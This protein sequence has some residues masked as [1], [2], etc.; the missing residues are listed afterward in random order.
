MS[1]I[2][3][4]TYDI[5]GK[6][7]SGGG[8]IVYLATHK[9]L[10]K[11]VVLKA[12]KRSTKTRTELLRRE[13]DILKELTNTYIPQV[14]DYF[15]EGDTSYTVMDYVEG[16]SLNK[17]LEREKRF[18]QPVVIKWARQLLEALVYLHSPTH[19]DPPRGYIHSDIKPG[20]IMLRPSGDI[21]LIDFNISLAIGIESIVGRSP[22]YSSPEH[23]GLDY[24]A[25]LMGKAD[26]AET[27][28]ETSTDDGRDV[29]TV[30]ES[31]ET[32]TEAAVGKSLQST[33]GS[34]LSSSLKR[35]TVLDARSDIYSVGATLYHLLSGKRPKNDAR[36][37][38]PLS[39]KEF[40]PQLV[41]IITK[42]M[43]PNPDMRYATAAEMLEAING[44]WKNDPRVKRRKKQTI[45]VAAVL[46]LIYATG[47]AAIYAGM[48]QMER[49]QA[50]QV[51]AADSS[52]AFS[53]GDVK[54]ALD[55]ALEAL[56][57][58]PGMFDLP[59]TPQAQ[60]ALTD[61]LGIYDLSDSFKPY[62]K[63]NLPSAPFRTVKSPDGT[64]FIVTYAYELAIYDFDTGQP[65][66]TMPTLESAL[67][68]VEFLND[69]KIV[70]GGKEGL[71]AYD[72]SS[73]TV[74]WEVSPATAIAVSGDSQTV[75]AI[76]GREDK[77]SF[78]NAVTGE[79]ITE[80]SLEGRHLNIP[81][82]DMYA[83]AMRDVFELDEKGEFCA[84]SLS[85][86]YLG[87]L[88]IKDP[89]RD[90]IIFD[91]T[92]DHGYTHFEGA[93][94]KNDFAFS[95][96][97]NKGALFGIIDCKDVAY[98]GD[99]TSDSLYRLKA[100]KDKLYV[101]QNATAVEFNT[102]TFEQTE[103]AFTDTNNINAFDI[104]DNYVLAATPEG[105]S[106][107]YG[108]AG[109]LQSNTSEIPQDFVLV[110][111]RFIAL[112]DRNSPAIEVL[113]LQSHDDM[114][115]ISYD[116]QIKHYEARL[117]SDRSSVMLFGID[118]FTI[119]NADGGV[120]LSAA[121]PEPDKIYDQQ[122]RRDGGDCLEVTYYSGKIVSYS[123]DN[124][125]II[126][127]TEGSPPDKG[128]GEEF[129]TEQFIIKA[130]LQGTPTVYSKESGEKLTDLSSEDDLTYITEVDGYIIA[131]YRGTD[132]RY[133]G[134]LMNNDCEPIAR[135]PNLCDISGNSLVF[136]FPSGNI[137][138]SPIYELDELK[139]RA[140][141][142]WN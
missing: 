113:R 118:G 56:P 52:K 22:G 127:E 3:D 39:A 101:I 71:T 9:R 49:L 2:I 133:Y 64:K 10:G 23:Y 24:S 48:H 11:K 43:N 42:A 79:L 96:Y 75:A 77:I 125:E 81:E 38:E 63:I 93:F 132:G 37:V 70:F 4:S 36:E 136:D 29:T 65:I 95:A 34:S 66:K 109:L 128:A 124:G 142:Y 83:D 138:I 85:G 32:V 14:Y 115:L 46:A 135:L 1:D 106:V 12:D 94:I 105:Y 97:G 134:V 62:Y 31:E 25:G 116:P 40:S 35:V 110:T 131:Q 61:A 17:V 102:D 80:R 28:T 60:L 99:M 26:N 73:D 119:L 91:E 103:V 44:L 129:E 126:S 67:C 30:T 27:V 57:D 100:Y 123:A 78:Y 33:I 72:I 45:A 47:G 117:K 139:N 89:E 51:L 84:V 108:G 19:G 50:A 76:N 6:L 104:S 53:E 5:I 68:E 7:G 21:C 140:K 88:N 41:S 58:N 122:F 54:T 120:K 13:V 82:N 8:G 98:L 20:N 114:K 69:T 59:Y 92:D 15:I 111:D 87:V 107:F 112:A 90:L 18:A 121:L 86:E 137:K 74:L 141:K 130:P 16:E 55:K